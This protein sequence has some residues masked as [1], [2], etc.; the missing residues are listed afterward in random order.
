M[1]PP[2][3]KTETSKTCHVMS[4]TNPT[5]NNSRG[6]ETTFP[7]HPSTTTVSEKERYG[8]VM[9]YCSIKQK[10]RFNKMMM[11]VPLGSV[12]FG[13]GFFAF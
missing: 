12:W 9:Y 2:K 7:F 4:P 1:Y 5:D 8:V 11:S 6:E 13:C 10:L 3:I